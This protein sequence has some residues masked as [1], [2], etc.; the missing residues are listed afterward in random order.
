MVI[1]TVTVDGYT[2]FLLTVIAILLAVVAVGLWFETPSTLP[3]AQAEATGSAEQMNPG[4]QLNQMVKNT[5]K[6]NLSIMELNKLMV[7]GAVKVQVVEKPD[8]KQPIKATTD[9]KSNI[10]K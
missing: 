7:S 1:M 2:R 8:I 3:A 6:L 10:D 4:L 9:Q 5:E